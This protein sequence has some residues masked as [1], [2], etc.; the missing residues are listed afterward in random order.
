MD[1]W[2]DW[3]AGQEEMRDVA[4]ELFQTADALPGANW[5]VVARENISH[6]LRAVPPE[7][8]ERPVW[9]LF[10]IIQ[11][12][13]E[14][15]WLSVCFYAD[16]VEDPDERGDEIPGGLLG[17]DGYCFDLDQP[18]SAAAAYIGRVLTGVHHNLFK[19]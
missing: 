16:Q 10:D 3:P 13:G 12:P 18:D 1:I 17:S 2:T 5:E 9:M 6:S 15:W 7:G 14:P 19:A 8:G 11:D 4:R